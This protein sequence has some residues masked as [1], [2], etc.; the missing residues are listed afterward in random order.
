MD[1]N[2]MDA[3]LKRTTSQ[4]AKLAYQGSFLKGNTVTVKRVCGYPGCRCAK[5]GKKHVS[6][7]VGKK[8]D[9]TT[10][11]IYVP[12]RLEEEVEK[13][14]NTYH[15]IKKLIE[16]ISELNYAQLKIK[17]EKKIV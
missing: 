12:K 3:E 4:L 15:R 6:M 8:Q 11:M 5:E 10:K 17:K 14:V 13:K 2:S 9:G 16:R 1:R 7:Y